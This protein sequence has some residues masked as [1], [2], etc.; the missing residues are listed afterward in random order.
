MH[1]DDASQQ[2]NPRKLFVG[3]IA[4]TVT[5][6]QLSELFSQYGEVV[7][8]KLILDRATGRSKGI[9]FVEY[10][11]EEM[12]QAAIEATNGMEFEGRAL[13][14]NVARPF[15]PRKSFDGPQGGRGGFGGGRPGGFGG[16][17]RGG[18][19]GGRGFGGG[20]RGG[21]RGD[22]NRGDSNSY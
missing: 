19:G 22:Y 18:S 1:S 11:T 10:S 21:G 4:F 12:A 15:Q 13:N 14:V 5:E 9:A 6:Q 3:N 17:N 2:V 8:L 16:G 7:D 20:N